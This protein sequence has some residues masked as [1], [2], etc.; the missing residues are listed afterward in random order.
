MFAGLRNLKVSL[1]SLS[2][3]SLKFDDLILQYV[4]C[5]HLVL[6]YMSFLNLAI[7]SKILY[8]LP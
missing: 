3:E 6:N 7:Y 4:G 5:L 8:E 1:L 2:S